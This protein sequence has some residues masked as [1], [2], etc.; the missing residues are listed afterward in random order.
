MKS[1]KYKEEKKILKRRWVKKWCKKTQKRASVQNSHIGILLIPFIKCYISV[2]IFYSFT[3]ID[4]WRQ[5]SI[6]FL[7]NLLESF[8]VGKRKLYFTEFCLTLHILKGKRVEPL[9]VF[10][11][12]YIT[13]FNFLIL[14]FFVFS[15]LFW[16]NAISDFWINKVLYY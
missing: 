5:E 1:Y 13:F 9:H 11:N 12:I 3:V 15:I 4:L 7:R 2:Y 10:I 8:L 14:F 16:L 6:W